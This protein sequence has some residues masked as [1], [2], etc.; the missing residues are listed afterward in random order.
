LIQSGNLVQVRR[1][2]G[3]IHGFFMMQGILRVAR[4]AL[5]DA[6]SFLRLHLHG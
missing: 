2:P 6:G 1:Y 4:E 5:H 3:T